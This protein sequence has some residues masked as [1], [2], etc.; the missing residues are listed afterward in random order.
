MKLLFIII[1]NASIEVIKPKIIFEK[2]NSYMKIIRSSNDILS[3]LTK[4]NKW[5]KLKQAL[6]VLL[7]K[8]SSL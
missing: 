2:T 3:N 4:E 7:C 1:E 6:A 8:K 5:K